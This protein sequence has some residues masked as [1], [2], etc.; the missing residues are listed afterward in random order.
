MD[1]QLQTIAAKLAAAAPGAVMESAF[2]FGELTLTVD[3]GRLIESA[4]AC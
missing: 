4:K 2:T 3:L 1:D